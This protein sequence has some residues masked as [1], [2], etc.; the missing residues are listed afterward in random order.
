VAILHGG[1]AK[2]FHPAAIS[3]SVLEVLIMT[4]ISNKKLFYHKVFHDTAI[5]SFPG[6]KIPAWGNLS[7]A[8]SPA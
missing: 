5:S 4:V 7:L 8:K 6:S 3:K 1:F 2:Q